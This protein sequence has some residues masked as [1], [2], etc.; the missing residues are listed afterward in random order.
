MERRH[1]LPLYGRTK[2]MHALESGFFRVAILLT[3][4]IGEPG[5]LTR[6]GPLDRISTDMGTTQ[7]YIQ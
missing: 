6:F 1:C 2:S 7:S 4:F 5:F 3:M